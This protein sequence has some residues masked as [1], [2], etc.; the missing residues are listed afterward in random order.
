MSVD[1][2]KVPTRSE[3]LTEYTWDL[4]IVFADVEA[5]ERELVAIEELARKVAS[6][7]GSLG[8]SGEHLG[9]VMQLRDEA[10]Q[11]IYALYVYAM[12][13]KDS[14]ATDPVGQALQ[15]RAGSFAARVMASM[16]YV[17][18]E[19]LTI[20]E[21][22]LAGWV[23]ET[24]ALKVYAYEFEKLNR[25]RAH[26]RSAEVEGVLA[27]FSDVTRAPYEV[28]E[29]LSDSDL[30]F[31]SIT[32]ENGAT[33]QLSHARYGRFLESNKRQVRHDAFK[34]YYGAYRPFRNTMATTLGA[35][36]RTHVLD[37]RIRNYSS[38]LASALEPNE[39]PLEVYHNLL[40]TVEANLGLNHRYMEIRKRL[41]GLDELRIYDL[42]AQPVP[43]PELIVPYD[44]AREMMLAAFAP[45]GDQYAAALQ[46]AF[47]SRWIDVYENVGKRSGAYSGGAYSTPP[48]VLLNYQDRLNDAF[49]LAHELGHSMHSFFSRRNQPFIYGGY[50]I[51]VAEV[52]STLNEALLTDYLLKHRD[53]EQLRRM[54]LVQQIEDIRRTIIRQTM[55]ASFELDMHTRVEAGEPLTS[56]GLSKRY[57]DLVA[58]YHGPAVTL[59]DEIAFEWM[60]IPH[61]YYKFYVYQYAT[62]LSAALALSRQLMSEGAPAVERY[63]GF[64]R[65]GSSRSSIELLRGAGVDMATPAPVQAA[66]ETFGLLLE[67]LEQMDG[68]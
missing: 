31:P 5:W 22:I 41:M 14:D 15:E 39:I 47:G 52:A 56:D 50:T 62:G 45:L 40:A 28:F 7:Q 33:V 30:I 37:A 42:Y 68:A 2:H 55:F 19:I 27:Q 64:L 20:P 63:L 48:Y 60:R 9:E 10:A 21:E 25:Q 23:A 59:D 65:G 44:E 35:S 32:D 51:F 29:M 12:H 46:Q 53:D 26:I 66:M 24:E 1:T 11:R 17:E 43:T 57:Y 54:L 16:A 13:R 61:F 49:T 67:Q 58:R 36:I 18:P 8:Q 34:G 4:S 3:A 6:F 38:A